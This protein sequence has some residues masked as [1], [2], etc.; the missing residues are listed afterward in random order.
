MSSKNLNLK[1]I[2][3]VCIDIQKGF[4]ESYWGMRNN[5]DAEKR[6]SEVLKF[7]RDHELPVIHVKQ[8]STDPNSP[9]YSK[10]PGSELKDFAT[11]L[12][13]ELLLEKSISCAFWGS[14][15]KKVL[16]QRGIR[17]IVL[18]G[19]T[20]DHGIST[21]A[22]SGASLG[23]S[24]F[25]LSDATATFDRDGEIG[26]FIIPYPAGVVHELAL[27]SLNNE[28]A[29]IMTTDNFIS[30]SQIDKSPSLKHS[31]DGF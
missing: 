3:L 17:K 7:F 1:N 31:M 26:T 9:L 10:S 30:S 24:V 27:A 18:C 6:I 11:P 4:D 19:L 25:V 22:R 29:Q 14:D 12:K 16:D 15:L 23:F 2:A 21:T 8:T 5:P 20:T 28:F 13:H